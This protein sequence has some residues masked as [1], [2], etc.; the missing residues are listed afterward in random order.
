M[1]PAVA[2]LK[3]SSKVGALHQYMSRICA[4]NR[5]HFLSSVLGIAVGDVAVVTYTVFVCLAAVLFVVMR[6]DVLD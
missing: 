5:R 6:I 2:Y 3:N 4:L 1:L